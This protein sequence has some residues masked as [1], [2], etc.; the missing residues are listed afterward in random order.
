MELLQN[1]LG[2][3][4]IVGI[5]LLGIVGSGLLAANRMTETR[6]PEPRTNHTERKTHS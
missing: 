2:L 4:L 5:T 6:D 1:V 3:L